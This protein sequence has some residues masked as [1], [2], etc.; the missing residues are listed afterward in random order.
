MARTGRRPGHSGARQAILEAAREAFCE[1][2]YDRA[3][4]RAIAGRA[5]VDPAL[6]HHYFGTKQQLFVAAVQLPLQPAEV[7]GQLPDGDPGTV[8]ERLIRFYLG[9][10]DN[11]GDR[12]V[13]IGLL[14]SAATSEPAAALLRQFAAEAG[15]GWMAVQLDPPNA[16]LRPTLVASQLIGLFMLRYIIKVEPLAS[17]SVEEVVAAVAPTVQRYLTAE[18]DLQPSL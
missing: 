7:I 18:L 4:I 17:A 2:G 15:I 3:S 1:H 9:I 11:R 5:R 6:V 14:R 13:V 16:R 12:D 8:G 10:G